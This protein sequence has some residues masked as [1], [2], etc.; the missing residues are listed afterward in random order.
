MVSNNDLLK[1]IRNIS[2]R[3]DKVEEKLQDMDTK[4]DNNVAEVNQKINQVHST[5]STEL[6]S[7]K[8]DMSTELAKLK[9]RITTL[10]NNKN[11]S[12]KAT[13]LVI[14]GIPHLEQENLRVVVSKICF[15]IK[16]QDVQS[17]LGIHRLKS[18]RQEPSVT[19]IGKMT[20]IIVKFTTKQSR[21][22]FHMKYF[23][24]TKIGGLKLSHVD[25]DSETRVY[26][27]ENLSKQS[28]ELLR[29]AKKLVKDGKIAGA[30]S[31]DGLICVYYSKNDKKF[32]TLS[33]IDDLKKFE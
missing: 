21:R 16:F 30:Y 24:F 31:Y 22:V 13:D 6:S 12:D 23:A 2:T 1:E 10:E 29:K 28:L 15:V 8:N 20:P 27:N 4:L 7:M 19:T 5:L 33:A 32:E 14:N 9:D 25:I 26:I 3:F 18:T 17:I 11:N